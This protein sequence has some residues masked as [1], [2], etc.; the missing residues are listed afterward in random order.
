MEGEAPTAY[1]NCRASAELIVSAFDGLAAHIAIL[2]ANGY[3]VCVNRTWRRFAVQNGSCDPKGYIGAN[4]IDVCRR[5]A[6]AGDKLAAEAIGGISAVIARTS[7]RF[8]QRY[9]CHGPDGERWFLMTVTPVQTGTG[10]IIAHEDVTQLIRAENASAASERRLRLS[11]DAVHM[12]TIEID[13]QK[14]EIVFDLQQAKLL[15]LPASTRRLSLGELDSMLLDRGARPLKERITAAGERYSEEVRMRLPDSSERWLSFAIAPKPPVWLNS[16][17]YFGICFDVTERKL[18]EK[19]RL[20][21]QEV[22]HRA[23]NMLS[24]VLAIARQTAFGSIPSASVEK[25]EQRIAGLVASLDLLTNGKEQSLSALIQAQL[26]SFTDSFADQVTFEGPGLTM[27][28]A[29]VQALGMA[30]H[31]LATNSVKYGALSRSG[32]R[33]SIQWDIRDDSHGKQF[34]MLWSEHGGPEIEAPTSRGFGYTVMVSAVEASAGGKV[35]LRYPSSGLVWEL[36]APLEEI[37]V[38]PSQ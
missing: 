6:T 17:R 30:L 28:S 21:S 37:M 38:P 11:L 4:Y 12:G 10:T 35:Q 7:P 24:V 2:D 8:A 1:S 27:H 14:E 9:P 15:K 33:I 16:G 29:A 5:A 25:L 32:G 19:N 18:E 36:I 31:E 34:H 22:R 13:L 20:L 23:K 26:V 3:I